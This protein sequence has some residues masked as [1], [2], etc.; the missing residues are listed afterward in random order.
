MAMYAVFKAGGFSSGGLNF[1][2]KIRRNSVDPADLFIA[3]IG[4]MD[5]FAVGLEIANRI[6]ADGRIPGFVKKRYSS[7]NSG[8]GA[9]FEKGE[10][11][12][13]DLAGI[14]GAAGYGKTGISSGRQEYLENLL[15]QYLLKL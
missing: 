6:I 13:E 3:H 8:E 14:G 2:A 11:S 5:T 7:F 9:K 4:G 1:D 10:L 15:N 12:F